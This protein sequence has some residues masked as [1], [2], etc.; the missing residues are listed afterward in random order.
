MATTSSKLTLGATILGRNGEWFRGE[1]RVAGL[2]AT[3]ALGLALLAGGVFGQGRQPA[4]PTGGNPVAT[5]QHVYVALGDRDDARFA[6]GQALATAPRAVIAPGDRE[7]PRFGAVLPAAAP[8]RVVV[9][10]GDRDDP[11]FATGAT[12]ALPHVYIVMGDRDDPRFGR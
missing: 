12:P 6:G 2:V 9:A 11:R 5:P 4:P 8:P 10:A 7:D 1:R 3:A